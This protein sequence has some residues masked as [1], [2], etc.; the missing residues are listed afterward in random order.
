MYVT[1]VLVLWYMHCALLAACTYL[2]LV[3]ALTVH[4][5]VHRWMGYTAVH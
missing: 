1:A 3:V 4:A 2:T 5:V